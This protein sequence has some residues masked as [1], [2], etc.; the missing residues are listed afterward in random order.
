[1]LGERKGFPSLGKAS[2]QRIGGWGLLL[3][4]KTAFYLSFL[5]DYNDHLVHFG[6]WCLKGAPQTTMNGRTKQDSVHDKEP[7][8]QKFIPQLIISEG[9]TP[10]TSSQAGQAGLGYRKWT[11][12]NGEIA[13]DRAELGGEQWQCI[14]LEECHTA[15]ERPNHDQITRVAANC[16]CMLPPP[17][18][19]TAVI[20]NMTKAF[21]TYT[22]RG[23]KEGV[24][25]EAKTT[26]GH[27]SSFTPLQVLK[28]T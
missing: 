15:P 4:S 17:P 12:N 21:Q 6:Y 20:S 1:M 8:W 2:Q 5:S 18:K 27:N 26:T 16:I 10:L 9:Q 7:A 13:Q 11:S 25:L 23:K 14:Q 28:N 19:G 24:L 22:W 3:V